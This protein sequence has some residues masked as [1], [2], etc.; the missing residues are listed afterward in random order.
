MKVSDE[1]PFKKYNI[2]FVKLEKALK[3]PGFTRGYYRN[4][5]LNLPFKKSS[6]WDNNWVANDAKKKEEKEKELKVL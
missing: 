5:D 1:D 3:I 6:G 4:F 2:Y